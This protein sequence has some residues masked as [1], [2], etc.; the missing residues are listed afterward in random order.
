MKYCY[1]VIA[2]LALLVAFTA[3]K[4]ETSK[5]TPKED[6]LPEG[7]V[8]LGIVI[9]R[10]DG[11]TYNL[12]WAACNV[13]ET[14]FVS[15][16]EIYGDYYAWGETGAKTNY[17]WQSYRWSGDSHISLNKYCTNSSYGT[18][19]NITKLQKAENPGETMDDVARAKLGGKWRMPTY[20]EWKALK[21][22]TTWNTTNDYEGT[23]VKGI[24]ITSKVEGYEDKSIFLPYAGRR[25][26]ASL[27]D[28]G[29]HAFYW[30]SEVDKDEPCFAYSTCIT[31]SDG[32]FL[33][34]NY[35][36]CGEPVRAVTE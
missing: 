28:A 2:A 14:G 24:I 30:T 35:R 22:N 29:T 5:D 31:T 25:N 10:G 7:A 16:P 12:Y 33:G 11:T 1:S 27:D 3:C 32:S 18:V 36:E 20:T 26:G 9:T 17:N 21:D 4:K 13:C 19:D 23:G 34:G 6:K 8:D 15:S